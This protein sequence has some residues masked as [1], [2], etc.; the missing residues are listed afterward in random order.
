MKPTLH[1]SENTLGLIIDPLHGPI[2]LEDGITGSTDLIR[3]LLKTPMLARLRS[4]KQLGFASYCFPAADHTRLAHALGTM[5]VMRR[6]VDKQLTHGQPKA[7]RAC[8]KQ[9]FPKHFSRYTK[10]GDLDDAIATHVYVAGLLQD[11]GELPFAQ[12]TDVYFRPNA[13]EK[14]DLTKAIGQSA[15]SGLETKEFF[16]LACIRKA[17]DADQ[18]LKQHLSFDFLAYFNGRCVDSQGGFTRRPSPIGPHA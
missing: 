12:I 15:I 5:Q 1:T 9:A 18:F 11:V 4:I 2:Q 7:L 14:G 8:I 16:T 6:L 10:L 13:K 17:L 3:R